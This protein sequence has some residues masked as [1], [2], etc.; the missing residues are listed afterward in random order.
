LHPVIEWHAL[1]QIKKHKR[2]NDDS[3]S[4]IFAEF[5][6][7]V[8]EWHALVM[9]YTRPLPEMGTFHHWV[10]RWYTKVYRH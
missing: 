9:L 1:V 10:L 3:H 7:P 4:L 8:I 5:L 2:Y 6:H